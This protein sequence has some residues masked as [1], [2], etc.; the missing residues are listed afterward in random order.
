M[1]KRKA[2]DLTLELLSQETLLLGV[3]LMANSD[4]VHC[5][6]ALSLRSPDTVLNDQN[7][8]LGNWTEGQVEPV[9]QLVSENSALQLA[10]HRY[11]KI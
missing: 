11:L 6:K 9:R 2:S 10:S 1:I 5:W 7:I 3:R 8:T 4:Q